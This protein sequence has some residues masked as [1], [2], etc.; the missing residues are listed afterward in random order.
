MTGG[1]EGAESMSEEKISLELLGSRVL[2]LT[3]EVGDL[4]QRLTA[5]E[6]RVTALEHRL[7][8]MENRFG[9]MENRF[10]PW[11]VALG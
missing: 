7:T 4:Q 8:A 2:T 10:G 1:D 3:A 9:G 11:R 6:R 5:M